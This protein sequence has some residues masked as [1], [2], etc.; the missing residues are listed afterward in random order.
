MRTVQQL[1]TSPQTQH[2]VKTV[3]KQMLPPYQLLGIPWEVTDGMEEEEKEER[4]EKSGERGRRGEWCRIRS[5]N[6]NYSLKGKK[7]VKKNKDK[8]N[9]GIEEGDKEEKEKDVAWEI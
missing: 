7:K 6:K 1:H 8:F 2:Y 4:E 9:E 3:D 5:R